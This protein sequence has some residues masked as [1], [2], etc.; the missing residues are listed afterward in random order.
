MQ[1]PWRVELTWECRGLLAKLAEP[2]G[3]LKAVD[4]EVFRGHEASAP[5]GFR[6]LEGGRGLRPFILFMSFMV[7]EG[8]KGTA[9]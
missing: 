4:D 7:K 2:H 6:I 8:K 3:A 9:P 1:P 5:Q